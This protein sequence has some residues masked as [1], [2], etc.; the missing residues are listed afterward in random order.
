[1]P[2]QALVVIGAHDLRNLSGAE[3]FR[4]TEVVRH[5][6]MNGVDYD[7]AL[8]R[9][10]RDSGFPPVALNRREL[11]GPVKMTVAGW[12]RT[13]EANAVSVSD[14]LRKAETLL[15]PADRCAAVY[16]AEPS[17]P[18]LTENMLCAGR[19]NGKGDSGGPLTAGAGPDRILA[20]VVSWH[21]PGKYGV[22][23]KVSAASAWIDSV[24]K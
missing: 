15:V 12:G 17:A 23:A 9:L 6:K 22:F 20:G 14:R 1:M 18:A 21:L 4:I 24:T 11:K 19:N 5:P 16:S 13:T 8:L 3:T 7:L 2:A 10:D